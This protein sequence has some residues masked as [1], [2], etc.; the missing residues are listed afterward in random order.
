MSRT[1]SLSGC[2]SLKIALTNGCL[3]CLLPLNSTA[4]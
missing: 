2:R 3:S 1:G 4:E